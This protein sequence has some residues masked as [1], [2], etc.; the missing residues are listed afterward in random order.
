M[1]FSATNSDPRGGF[2]FVIYINKF[3]KCKNLRHLRAKPG[4][5]ASFNIT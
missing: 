1:Q 4:Q 5:F 2:I 3:K